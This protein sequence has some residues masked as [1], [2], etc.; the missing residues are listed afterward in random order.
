VYVEL[1]N[2]IIGSDY[3]RPINE[4]CNG[5][6]IEHLYNSIVQSLLTASYATVPYTC[7]GVYKHWWNDSLAAAKQKSI[8]T[9]NAWEAAGKP[10]SG[11]IFLTRNAVKREYRYLI[12]IHKNQQN[13]DMSDSLSY[14]LYNAQIAK[15]WTT[16]KGKVCHSSKMLPNIEGAISE[17]TASV[18]F[19]NYFE[20]LCK[21]S[22]AQYEKALSEKVH[23]L[24]TTT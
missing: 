13:Q 14:S 19:K 1:L 10:R 2:V 6:L 23:K 22:D 8:D 5:S 4:L 11:P 21:P 12:R 18:L 16:W 24:I 17:K 15:F 3:N 20:N 7:S 9:H